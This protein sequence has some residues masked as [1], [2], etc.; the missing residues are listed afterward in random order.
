MIYISIFTVTAFLIWIIEKKVKHMNLIFICFSITIILFP[1]LFG[2]LRSIHVGTDNYTY[3]IFFRAAGECDTYV[4]TLKRLHP[5]H[6][7]PLFVLLLYL[8]SRITDNYIGVSLFS[9][10]IAITFAYLA[11][12]KYRKIIPMWLF[13]LSYLFIQYC[14]S[15]NI[16]RQGMAISIFLYAS[17]YL[18]EEKWLKYITLIILASLL[19][20]SAIIALIFIPLIFFLK[21]R[22]K[23]LWI[24]CFILFSLLLI[25]LRRSLYEQ[26]VS[27]F[28][29]A[30]KYNKY[31]L[32]DG[33]LFSLRETVLRLPPLIIGTVF[34]KQYNKIFKNYVFFYTM[35]LFDL[36][37]AQL[38]Q[39]IGSASRLSLYFNSIQIILVTLLPS[40]F[41]E[42]QK[43]YTYLLVFGYNFFYWIIFYVL[44][45]YNFARPVYPYQLFI[46]S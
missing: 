4:Q 27:I 33:F 23:F 39:D 21:S 9:S 44:N 42:N 14:Y 3:Q 25:C 12:W 45:N 20:F 11:S 30:E 17:W 38:Y 1:V 46:W 43:K 41:K 8:V 26:V 35:L 37:I 15:W 24:P 7:E 22:Y 34:Y 5:Q 29:F 32:K 2:G 6:Q 16:V 40:V 31:V 10:L 36:V 28:K 13:M 18:Q 19:H